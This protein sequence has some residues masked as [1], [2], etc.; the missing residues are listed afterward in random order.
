MNLFDLM[1]GRKR[2]AKK[3]VPRAAIL[4]SDSGF[5]LQ[6][7]YKATRTNVMFAFAGQ[8]EGVA[9]VI[10]V[11]SA[12]PGA[13]KS[14]NTVNLAITFAKT[15]CR[16][17]LID[18]DLRCATVHQYL[19]V[20]NKRGLSN[21]LGGFSTF[22]ETVNHSDE[23]HLDYL[24][25]GSVPPNPSELLASPKMQQMLDGLKDQYDYIFIDTPPIGVVTDAVILAKIAT[26]TILVARKGYTTYEALRRTLR[27]IEMV[28]VRPIGVILIASNESVHYGG[29]GGYNYYHS[30]KHSY[31]DPHFGDEVEI[32][33]TTENSQNND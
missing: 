8:D 11:T 23:Y 28:G 7:A 31:E 20:K 1:G 24:T 26:G 2:F 27:S 30:K 22:E 4:R 14:T 9:K 12:E 13:G 18:A 16:V 15:G 17:L 29:L 25:A 6:E 19:E 10:A 21:V 33:E 3:F 5:T 32:E